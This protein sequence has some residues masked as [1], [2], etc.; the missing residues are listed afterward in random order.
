V[1]YSGHDVL[2]SFVAPGGGVR[3]GARD[4]RGLRS[5]EV[6]GVGSGSVT[7]VGSGSVSVG[8]G[9]V[10]VVGSGSASDGG[11]ASG[12][13]MGGGLSGA[14]GSDTTVGSSDGGLGAVKP[15]PGCGASPW[16]GPT[17]QW[18]SQPPCCDPSS[19]N[20]GTS[21]CQAIPPAST[22][23]AQATKGSPEYRSWHVYVPSNYD[24][25]KPT[26]VVYAGNQCDVDWS[27]PDEVTYNYNDVQLGNAILVDLDYD[28]YSIPGCYD[29]EDPQ[30]NDFSFFPWLQ[31]QI[32][33]QFCV[34]M[35]QEF[36]SGYSLG[37]ALG[38]QLNCAFPDNLRGFVLY[39]GY[40]P[41]ALPGVPG[42]QHSP[43]VD[44]P[45]AALFVQSTGDLGDPYAAILPGCARVLAQNGC[46]TTICDPSNAT[47]TMPYPVPPGVTLPG[48]DAGCVQFNGCPANYPVV[49]CTVSTDSRGGPG[50]EWGITKLFWDFMDRLTCPLGD[51]YFGRYP[52]S[53]SCAPC[54]GGEVACGNHF[55]VDLLNDN[56]NCGACGSACPSG[57]AC[58]N[59]TCG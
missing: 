30:S 20:Q 15:S 9:C 22:V 36:F 53:P 51:G 56:H 6:N 14:T 45:T 28:V 59:G 39:K 41:G 12:A 3:L 33:S 49:F 55:C 2:Y 44:Q 11:A 52:P 34:D 7:G 47:L 50:T 18:V 38:Q 1:R 17:G 23:P 16:N 58:R 21:A 27:L 26:R 46:T 24:P 37:A 13:G 19:N 29:V 35:N 8:S 25:S 31:S 32:E 5:R 43:C 10:T 4:A 48:A 54:P 57:G 40:E 42:A